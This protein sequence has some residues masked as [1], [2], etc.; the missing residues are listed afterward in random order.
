MKVKYYLSLTEHVTFNVF[1]LTG[2]SPRLQLRAVLNQND[3]MMKIYLLLISEVCIITER[4]VSY[5]SCGST[6][7]I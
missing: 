3:I 6:L 5:S 4:L 7:I 2:T 1:V